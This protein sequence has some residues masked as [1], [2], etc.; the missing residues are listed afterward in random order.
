[1]GR[2]TEGRDGSGTNNKV[3]K[4]SLITDNTHRSQEI[5]AKTC[6]RNELI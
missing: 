3:Q 1:M 6:T 2:D 4:I 5:V